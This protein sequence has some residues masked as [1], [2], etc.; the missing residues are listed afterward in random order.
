VGPFLLEEGGPVSAV[1]GTEERP[2]LTHEP[3][4]GTWGDQG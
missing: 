1:G 4:V 2:G 3:L